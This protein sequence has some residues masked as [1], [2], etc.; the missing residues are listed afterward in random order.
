MAKFRIY[1]LDRKVFI[2]EN[3]ELGY[4]YDA[5][6]EDIR[7][8]RWPPEARPPQAVHLKVPGP[9][10]F[11]DSTR[12]DTHPA[13]P[14]GGTY[15]GV[16]YV[17]DVAGIGGNLITLTFDGILTIDEVVTAYNDLNPD[18]MVSHDAADDAV[19]PIL[20]SI[21]LGGGVE[22]VIKTPLKLK[23]DPTRVTDI[24]KR[25]NAEA[26]LA[27]IAEKQ[28]EY[29][30]VVD[31][32]LSKKDGKQNSLVLQV[33][34]LFVYVDALQ[35]AAGIGDVDM[36]Q[37]GQDAKAALAAVNVR[38]ALE[39]A[40]AA[41]DSAIDDNSDLPFPGDGLPPGHKDDFTP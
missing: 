13:L 14:A 7:T 25:K 12:L 21:G 15:E 1:N 24:K 27:K 6:Q 32:A 22:E 23:V 28:A 4:S 2:F 16:N 8:V 36:S 5:D 37:E 11:A 35:T 19:V 9:A 26:R 18:N 17:A 40:K 31:T 33:Q 30:A 29:E 41:R 10:Q 3:P 38:G 39:A 20:G 34:N